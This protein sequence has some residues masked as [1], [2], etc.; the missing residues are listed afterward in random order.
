MMNNKGF[1]LIEVLCALAVVALVF[2]I[3]IKTV[4]ST[5]SARKEDTYKLMKNNIVS[6]GY[7][8]I[9]ECKAQT[10]DCDFSYE[11][12]N[13]FPAS[14]LKEMGYFSNLESP[15]DGRYLGDCLLVKVKYDNGIYVIDLEDKCY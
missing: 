10:I 7:N 13:A 8:Y 6:A 12:N 15:I 5:L 9:N 4:G 11:D 3:T 2:A 1:T 14:V